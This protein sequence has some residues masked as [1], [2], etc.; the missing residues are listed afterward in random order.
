MLKRLAF[1]ATLW[2]GTDILIRQGLQFITL[3][4]I[5][6]TLAPNDFGLIAMLSFLTGIMSIITDGGLSAAL[7]QK[8]EVTGVDESTLLYFNIAIG[9]ALTLLMFLSA[10]W[11]ADFYESPELIPLARIMAFSCILG[12]L[13]PAHLAILTRNLNFTLQT[14]ASTFS[15]ILSSAI[16]ITLTQLGFGLVALA[17]YGVLST[18]LMS[19]ALWKIHPWRPRER[20]SLD[21]FKDLARFGFYQSSAGLMEFTYSRIYT[22]LL[23]KFFGARELGLYSQADMLRQLPGNFLGSIVSRVA[24]PLIAQN[25]KNPSM[26]RRGFQLCIRSMMF[27]SA[28][29]LLNIAVLA[30]PLLISLFGSRWEDAAPALSILCLASLFYPLHILNIQAL[31]G[32]GHSRIVLQLQFIKIALGLG[33]LFICVPYGIYGIAWGQVILSV[34]SLLLNTWHIKKFIGYGLAAQLADF[35]PPVALAAF[36]SC[37]VLAWRH[38]QHSNLAPLEELIFGFTLGMFSYISMALALRLDS[39]RD[40]IS[41][42]RSSKIIQRQSR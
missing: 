38:F 23:G 27:L 24:L 21:S 16:T 4:L 28:P 26:L 30:D 1:N 40:T 41:I 20:F 10:P 19:L 29:L 42:A 3:V 25:I 7:I 15:A 17:L 33:I 2:S 14:K 12:S 34:L 13:A 11:I 5:A 8:K 18:G 22:P 31:Y 36:A 35:S 32:I 6:R 9:S 37:I 39:L